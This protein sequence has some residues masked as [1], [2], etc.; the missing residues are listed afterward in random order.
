MNI[1]LCNHFIISRFSDTFSVIF[2]S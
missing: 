1:K 2:N